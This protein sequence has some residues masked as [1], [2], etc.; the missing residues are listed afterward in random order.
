MEPKEI[1][2]SC[3]HCGTP[4]K[5]PNGAW[6]RERRLNAKVSGKAL[7]DRAHLSRQYICDIEHNRRHAPDGLLE[8]YEAL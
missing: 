3:P 1:V 8:V 2:E 6:L 4:K 5:R 7:A